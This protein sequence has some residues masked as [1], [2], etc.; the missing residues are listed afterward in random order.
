[1]AVSS[2]RLTQY[3]IECDCC[4]VDEC[5]PDSKTE[6]VHSLSQAIKWAK[7]HKTKEGKILCNKCFKEYKNNGA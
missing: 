1:M 7:M 4:G 3:V 5:C 6:N 2:Y